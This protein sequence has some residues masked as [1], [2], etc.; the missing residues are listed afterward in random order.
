MIAIGQEFKGIKISLDGGS[1]KDCKFDSC[2][3]VYS[4]LLPVTLTGNSF[5]NC[6]WE[7]V[8]AARNSIDFMR[9]LYSGGGKDLIEGTMNAI[10]G[11]GQVPAGRA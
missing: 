6:T 7:F 4:G 3:L 10:R 11:A 2:A 1:F 9:A 8:G 5:T